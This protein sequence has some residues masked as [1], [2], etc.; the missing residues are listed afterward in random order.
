MVHSGIDK[1]RT[2]SAIERVRIAQNLVK[3]NRA[4]GLDA[5]NDLFRGGSVPDPAL[6][7]RYSGELIAVD[8][9]PGLTQIVGAICSAWMPWKGKTFDTARS[10]GDN[11]FH[12]SSFGLAH[13]FWPLYRGYQDDTA[14]TYRAFAFRTYVAPGQA[15]P[16][17]EVFKIDYDLPTNPGPSIRR[18]LDELVQIDEGYY[19]GKAHL[20]W[21]WGKWQLVAYFSLCEP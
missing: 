16:D 2:E 10:Q 13:V 9:A 21:W 17:R 19:L 12:R 4:E 7:G 20:Q 6:D 14:E 15:D 18:V 8:L 5:L 11:I 3:I 1:T